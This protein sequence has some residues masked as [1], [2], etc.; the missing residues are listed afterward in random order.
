MSDTIKI[1]KDSLWKYSTIV[2]LALV[3]VLVIVLVNQDKPTTTGNVP[4]PAPQIPGRI[5]ASFDDDPFLGDEDAEVVV[6]EFSDYECPFCKR[7]TEQT[8]PSIKAEYLDGGKIKYVFRDYTPTLSNPS[9]HPNAIKTAIAAECAREI[10]GDEAYWEMHEANFDNQGSND[11]EN[12][13]K[14]ASSLGYDISSCL[15]SDKYKSEVEKDFSDG[16]KYGIRGT[17]GFLIGSEGNYRI[18]S[19]ACPYSAFKQVIDAELAGKEWSSP[20]NCQVVVN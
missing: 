12:L 14:T 5:A 16:Q 8:L 20:G 15:D 17:P 10:G 4:A 18:L 6:I 9:Y 3:V 7:H 2:L 19:G 11:A 1:K 13:K